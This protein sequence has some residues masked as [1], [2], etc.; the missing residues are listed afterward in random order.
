M[1]N[2]KRKRFADYGPYSY[3]N[4]L[5]KEKNDLPYF[6]EEVELFSDA[7]FEDKETDHGPYTVINAEPFPPI[8]PRHAMHGRL[9][10]HYESYLDSNKD[11]TSYPSGTDTSIYHGGCLKD[12]MA[13]LYSLCTG[14]RIKAGGVIREFYQWH[15]YPR[16]RIPSP[17]ETP[18]FSPPT[19]N[20]YMLPWHI[21]GKKLTSIHEQISFY[22]M[23][24]PQQASAL[25][26]AARLYQE[27]IW[28][29]E[30]NPE[31]SW[32]MLV[33]SV[34]V[35]ADCFYQEKNPDLIKQLEQLMP[36][37][38]ADLN[39][40]KNDREEALKIVSKH[41]K[42]L[43]GSTKKFQQFLSNFLPPEP[44]SERPPYMQVEWERSSL[45]ALSK[46]VYDH[47]SKALHGGTPFPQPMCRP[48]EKG[49]HDQSF[50]EFPH[51]G[52]AG[53]TLGSS[54]KAKD[55]PVHLHIFEY[56]VR[57]SLLNWWKDMAE[58][59]LGLSE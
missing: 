15:N 11:P 23:L 29:A 41:L 36:K 46:K 24:K 44:P 56:I 21:G 55:V 30:N 48:P 18:I 34:E 31:V 42:S 20:K 1:S 17:N 57:H 28:L 6:I 38:A 19:D 37:L 49:H 12:E 33:S 43:V 25:V 5:A 14:A 47:R 52:I 35:A 8:Q 58:H 39:N 22:S 50:A 32:L 7:F 53:A 4:W 3:R 40:L 59:K 16:P 51:V 13:A 27:G 45:V 10:L 9:V 2:S 26:R 54:W